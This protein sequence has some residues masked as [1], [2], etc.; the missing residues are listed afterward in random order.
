MQ[1]V[2]RQ[3]PRAA[4]QRVRRLKAPNFTATALR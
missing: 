4:G 3:H 2:R 1:V